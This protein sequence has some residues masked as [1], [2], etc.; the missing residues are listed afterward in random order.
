MIVRTSEALWEGNVKK[1]KGTVKVGVAISV[2]VILS[3]RGSKMNQVQTP[4]S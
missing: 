4:R 2:A 3:D 1:G